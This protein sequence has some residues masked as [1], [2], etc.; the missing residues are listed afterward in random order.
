MD[1]IDETE[2]ELDKVTN[3]VGILTNNLHNSKEA[4]TN[5]KQRF[6]EDNQDEQ[7]SAWQKFNDFRFVDPI[8][9]AQQLEDFEY[10]WKQLADSDHNPSETG[11]QSKSLCSSASKFV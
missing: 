3:M 5:L 10:I 2:E 9:I 4:F 6:R 1:Y 7:Q 11:K 8:N